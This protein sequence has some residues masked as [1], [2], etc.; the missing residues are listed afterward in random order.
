MEGDYNFTLMLMAESISEATFYLSRRVQGSMPTID[1][2]TKSIRVYLGSFREVME[3]F[4]VKKM[5]IHFLHKFSFW[6]Y[7]RAGGLNSSTYPHHL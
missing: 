7:Q 6:V 4:V 5:P 1:A 2:S 3:I